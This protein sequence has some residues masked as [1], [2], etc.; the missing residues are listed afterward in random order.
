MHAIT[1]SLATVLISRVIRIYN[2][3]LVQSHSQLYFFVDTNE[4]VLT[5]SSSVHART[6]GCHAEDESTSVYT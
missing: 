1:H 4:K 2:N 3:S 6:R 5:A